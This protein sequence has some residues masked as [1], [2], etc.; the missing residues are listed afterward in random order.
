MYHHIHSKRYPFYRCTKLR[1]RGTLC[2][3]EITEPELIPLTLMLYA[4][5]EGDKICF[6]YS[7]ISVSMTF[8]HLF[9]CLLQAMKSQEEHS[10]LGSG[11]NDVSRV[12][13]GMTNIEQLLG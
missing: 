8:S 2:S 10:R 9:E 13:V 3:Q 12:G 1:H 4:F 6:S 7:L 5:F 11:R